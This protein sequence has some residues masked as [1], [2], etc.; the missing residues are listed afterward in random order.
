MNSTEDKAATSALIQNQL[1]RMRIVNGSVFVILA[2]TAVIAFFLPRLHNGILGPEGN[3]LFAAAAAL[4]VGFTANRDARARLERIKRAY[5]VHADLRRLMRDYLLVY[6]I[7]Q[8]RLFVVAVCGLAVAVWGAGPGL[9]VAFVG[10]AC[11]LNLMAWPTAHKARLLVD[12]ANA[13][14]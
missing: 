1:R 3:T 4:W 13:L 8:F 5:A 9:A 7:V 12:R 10:L 2:S 11:L 14:R 6:L